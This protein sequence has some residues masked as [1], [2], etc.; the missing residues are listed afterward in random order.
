VLIYQ[1]HCRLCLCACVVVFCVCVCVNH[2]AQDIHTH[3]GHSSKMKSLIS[4][5]VNA[6]CLLQSNWNVHQLITS[7]HGFNFQFRLCSQSHAVEQ[8][9]CAWSDV[10]QHCSRVKY[11]AQ[12]SLLGCSQKRGFC[13]TFFCMQFLPQNTVAMTTLYILVVL[14]KE[15]T[16]FKHT[17]ADPLSFYYLLSCIWSSGF[18]KA[19]IILFRL[20]FY[21]FITL[22]TLIL[23]GMDFYCVKQVFLL[24]R[25]SFH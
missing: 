6:T 16:F 3:S 1:Y 11:I 19:C 10:P 8:C 24:P 12:L 2:K 5:N 25:Y 20:S 9:K 22:I 18:Q 7:Q 14:H 4:I 15:H 23:G 13:L 17:F 21:N